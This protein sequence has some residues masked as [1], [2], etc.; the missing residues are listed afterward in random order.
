MLSFVNFAMKL[1]KIKKDFHFHNA[2]NTSLWTT[3]TPPCSCQPLFQMMG[4]LSSVQQFWLSRHSPFFHFFLPSELLPDPVSLTEVLALPKHPAFQSP[5]SP[6]TLSHLLIFW[7]CLDICGLFLFFQ[8]SRVKVLSKPS[9]KD[10]KKTWKN[11]S[12]F[13]S[14][15]WHYSGE[16]ALK[17]TERQTIRGENQAHSFKL[18]IFPGSHCHFLRSSKMA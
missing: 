14:S 1:V 17:E 13:L 6:F 2:R 4:S 10:N 12:L 3:L 9:S 15:Q 18:F 11:S 7:H 5:L 8:P 16:R